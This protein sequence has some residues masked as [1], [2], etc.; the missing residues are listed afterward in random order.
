MNHQIKCT[1]VSR[2]AFDIQ[3]DGH[4]L[5]IDDAEGNTGPRPKALLLSALA[6]CTGMDIVSI[7]EKMRVDFSQFNLRVEGHLT[8][9][10]PKVYDNIVLIYEI[11]L[12]NE[13]DKKNMEKAVALSVEKYCGVHAM[14]NKASHVTHQ[15]EYL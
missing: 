2:S 3:Q 7:L 6:A 11:K 4:T 1:H 8:E 5:R 10:H 14:L 15:I 12:E 13:G 9:D